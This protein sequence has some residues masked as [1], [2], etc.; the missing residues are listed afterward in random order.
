MS[1]E[2]S[3]VL[4]LLEQGLINYEEALA[5]LQALGDKDAGS[6]TPANEV[7]T[8]GGSEE[9][10]SGYDEDAGEECCRKQELQGLGEEIGSEIR[11]ALQEAG[12]EVN[13]ALNEVG[14]ELRSLGRNLDLPGLLQGIFSGDFS[15]YQTWQETKEVAVDSSIKALDLAVNNKNGSV[16]LLATD[17]EQITARLNLRL[18]A[19]SE[20]EARKLAEAY[21]QEQQV[22]NGDTLRLTWQVAEQIAGSVAFEILVP[23]RLLVALDLVSKNGSISVQNVPVAGEVMTKNG[24]VTIEGTAYGDLEVETKNGS[25]TIAADVGTLTATSKNGSVRCAVEPVR[26]GNINLAANNGSV[27]AELVCRDD[28]GYKLEAQTRSGRVTADLPSLVLATREKNH[29]NGATDNWEQARI[30][31]QVTALSKN[32]SITLS[33]R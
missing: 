13:F 2:K 10:Q 24:S 18:Q 11:E 12:R 7:C 8:E 6:K 27:Q 17:R 22:V 3:Q 21:L 33:S 31:T 9:F 20:E 25:I 14:E 28:I 16:R 19:A 26:N 23:H 15:K 29:L 1:E 4:R 30:K 32:G 5:L